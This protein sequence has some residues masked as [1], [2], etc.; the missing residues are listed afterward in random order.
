MKFGL[1]VPFSDRDLVVYAFGA[2]LLEEQGSIVVAVRSVQTK[3]VADHHVTLPPVEGVRSSTNMSAH[4]FIPITMDKTYVRIVANVDLDVPGLPYF[5]INFLA[6]QVAHRLI[7]GL[8]EQAPSADPAEFQVFARR[9]RAHFTK[10]EAPTAASWGPVQSEE[11]GQQKMILHVNGKGEDG[12]GKYVTI[13]TAVNAACPGDTIII[14]PGEY[15]EGG[16]LVVT[17]SLSIVRDPEAKEDADV[18]LNASLVFFGDQGAI[19]GITIRHIAG[20]S[21]SEPGENESHADTKRWLE[22]RGTSEVE[23]N[24]LY[25][26]LSSANSDLFC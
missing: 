22:V 7:V 11:G 5:L 15:H 14:H 12:P 2:D 13:Q 25:L 17:K 10:I 9:L 23:S 24:H 16:C 6:K 18:V 3:D 1:P 21:A 19:K 20:A 4:Q 26:L 8:R